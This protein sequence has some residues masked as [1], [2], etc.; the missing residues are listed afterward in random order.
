VNIGNQCDQWEA[1][2]NENIT[3]LL[4]ELSALDAD[5]RMAW[6]DM[7]H[8]PVLDDS[9]TS[10][11]D[12]LR[13]AAANADADVIEFGMNALKVYSSS[14]ES[15]C[16]AYVSR[17]GHNA[18]RTSRASRSGERDANAGYRRKEAPFV[19]EACKTYFHPD[20]PRTSVKCNLEGGTVDVWDELNNAQPFP[21]STFPLS[22]FP[23]DAWQWLPSRNGQGKLRVVLMVSRDQNG[24]ALMYAAWV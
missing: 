17:A 6:N 3:H 14:V 10:H 5:A 1:G 23:L 2:T 4:A 7:S 12:R 18:E 9:W 11:G 13:G 22:A 24:G 15:I 19:V 21:V 16:R 8:P 20:E